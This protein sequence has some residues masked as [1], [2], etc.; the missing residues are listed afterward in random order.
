MDRT[1]RRSRW[2]ETE[3]MLREVRLAIAPLHTLSTILRE[4]DTIVPRLAEPPRRRRRYSY[5]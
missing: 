5:S 4:W 1:L 2:R 3:F